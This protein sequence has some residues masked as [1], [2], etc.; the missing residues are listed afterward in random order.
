MLLAFGYNSKLF[1]AAMLSNG[2]IQQQLN[3]DGDDLKAPW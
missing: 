3:G 1:A 2:P